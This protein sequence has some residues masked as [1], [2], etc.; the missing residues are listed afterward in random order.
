MAQLRQDYQQFLG[1][2][3]EI[4]VVNPESAA[5]VKDFAESHGLSFPMLADPGHEVANRYGQEVNML[6]LG[7]LPALV[8]LDREGAV[9]YEHRAA[10]MMDT[11]K[12]GDVLS[13]LNRLNDEW[14]GRMPAGAEKT[15]AK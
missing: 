8:V 10:S 14:A 2:E 15:L 12:N 11:A 9:R 5:E 3:A 4:L 7:R 1:R 13:V 6:K